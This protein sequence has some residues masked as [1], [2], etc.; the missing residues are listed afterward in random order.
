MQNIK[1]HAGY[2]L[3]TIDCMSLLFGN[4]FKQD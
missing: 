4:P 2:R 1:I 3:L